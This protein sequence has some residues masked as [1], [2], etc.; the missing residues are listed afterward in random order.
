MQKRT[1][2]PDN[3]NKINEALILF[4]RMRDQIWGM[5]TEGLNEDE[6]DFHNTQTRVLDNIVSLVTSGGLKNSMRH[7]E[8]DVKAY[9]LNVA[10][11]NR[12]SNNIVNFAM[13]YGYDFKEM[14]LMDDLFTLSRLAEYSIAYPELDISITA[15]GGINSDIKDSIREGNWSVA[16]DVDDETIH[17][18]RTDIS[19][20]LGLVLVSVVNGSATNLTIHEQ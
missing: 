3:S 4:D 19:S 18:D 9:I 12:K 10:T 15:H 14:G 1:L 7:I 5:F 6:I 16:S 17:S 20:V 2:T 13:Q 8:D 11:A